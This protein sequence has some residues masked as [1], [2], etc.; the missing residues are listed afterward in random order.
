[1]KG[2]MA[3]PELQDTPDPPDEAEIRSLIEAA[4]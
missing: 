1:M 2:I 4:W 3:R